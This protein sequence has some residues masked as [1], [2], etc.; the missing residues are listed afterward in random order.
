MG[1]VGVNP[2]PPTHTHTLPFIKKR[3]EN[4]NNNIKFNTQTKFDKKISFKLS[5]WAS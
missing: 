2:P 1:F 4:A 3:R 5:A